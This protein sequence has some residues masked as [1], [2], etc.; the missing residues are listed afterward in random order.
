MAT[1]RHVVNE[2][3]S[4]NLAAAAQNANVSY[5]GTSAVTMYG[6]EARQEN[7]YRS[8]VKPQ[9]QAVFQKAAGMFAARYAAQLATQGVNMTALAVN[10]PSVLTLPGSF[11]ENNV[12]PFDVPVATAVDFVGLIYLLVLSFVVTV[13]TP[14]KPSCLPT[15]TSSCR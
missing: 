12:R 8:T 14:C 7:A 3:A 6:N 4:A 2:G 10:A 13:C 5:N 11:V 15:L 1:D 9:A